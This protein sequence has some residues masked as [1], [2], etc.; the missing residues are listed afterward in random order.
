MTSRRAASRPRRRNTRIVQ[1]D[2]PQPVNPYPPVELASD[3]EVEAIFRTALQI[4]QEIGIEI[5]DPDSLS[6]LKAAGADVDMQ[7]QRVRFDSAFI[8]EKLALAPGAFTLWTRNP[9]RDLRMGDNRLLFTPVGGPAFCTDLDRGRRRGSYGE[10]CEFL[11]LVQSLNIMHFGG[12]PGGPFEPMDL[13]VASRYLDVNYALLTVTD[14]CNP[15][16]AFGR[17]QT[18]DAIEMTRIA[19]GIDHATMRERPS[20][21]CIINTNSPL[22]LDRPMAEGLVALVE[23]G[24]PPVIT[25]PASAGAMAPVTLAGAMAQ[26]SAEVMACV[27]LC[28]TVKPG[29]PLVVSSGAN[30]VDMRTGGASNGMPGAMQARLIGAQLGRRYGVPLRGFAGA[31]SKLVDAQAGYETASGLWGSIM[32]GAN[33]IYHAGGWIEQGLTASYEKLIMDAEILQMV[34]GSLQRLEIS[35]ETLGLE[36]VREVGPGG[37]YFGARHTLRHYLDSPYVPLVS[38]WGNHDAWQSAGSLSTA[39]RANWVWKRLLADYEK[40]AL[41][42]AIDEELKAYMAGR[43]QQLSVAA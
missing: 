39:E 28:Q 13:P 21:M 6:R 26:Q 12:S 36:A 20:V 14:K 35:D 9:E 34:A 43:K 37:H 8:E 18:E 7:N 42:P 15:S 40:P 23:A 5:W 25:P 24:Q 1:P 10:M 19:M 41:D 17:Q 30:P 31:V 27:A 22:R 33:L 38:D 2:W 3:D 4:L 16:A 32:S 29:A 11:S